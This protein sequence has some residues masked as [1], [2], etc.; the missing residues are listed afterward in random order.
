MRPGPGCPLRHALME[1]AGSEAELWCHT[2]E[3]WKGTLLQGQTHN[4]CL[5]LPDGYNEIRLIEGV[6][7]DALILPS[8]M[9]ATA[10]VTQLTHESGHIWL[11]IHVFTVFKE[12]V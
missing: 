2:A 3:D 11:S 7:S 4:F 6:E 5:K 1:L 9:T 8:L 10:R 12:R